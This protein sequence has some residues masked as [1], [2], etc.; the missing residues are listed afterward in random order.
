MSDNQNDN[1]NMPF[2]GLEKLDEFERQRILDEAAY[3]VDQV[4]EN[5][6]RQIAAGV[7]ATCSQA[8]AEALHSAGRVTHKQRTQII[9][10]VRKQHGLSMFNEV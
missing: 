9:A 4:N 3:A 1:K 5:T 8:V 7:Q 2:S 10:R 6:K